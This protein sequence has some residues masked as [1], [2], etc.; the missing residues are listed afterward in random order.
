MCAAPNSWFNWRVSSASTLGGIFETRIGLSVL[1]GL[2][3]R[4]AQAGIVNPH[5][6]IHSTGWN[7]LRTNGPL[8]KRALQIDRPPSSQLL[9]PV[10]FIVLISSAITGCD[11]SGNEGGIAPVLLFN[12]SGSSRGDVRAIETLL[13]NNHLKYST[14]NSS[15]LNRMSASRLKEYRLV[16]VPGGNFIEIGNGLTSSTTTNIR[17][18]VHGGLNYLGICAGAF[19]AGNS[20]TNGLNLTSGVTFKFYSAEAQGIR[21]AAVP[22]S[23]A[24]G[25]TLEHYWE[26]GPQLSGWGTVVGKYPDGRPQPVGGTD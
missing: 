8:V 16:I 24:G 9:L 5:R 17:T 26:D 2:I 14:V 10:L 21:K 15:Q 13:R 6:C 4:A 11:G 3:S 12:G 25:P 23:V 7:T 20:P 19:F 18:A 22:I 1:Y